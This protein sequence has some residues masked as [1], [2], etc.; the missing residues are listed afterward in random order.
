MAE[1]KNL[2]SQEEI[3]ALTAGIADGSVEVDTGFNVEVRAR[4]H[5]LTNEDSSLGVNVSSIDM[6]NERFIRLFRLG[7]L[8]V[9]RTSPRVNPS[10]TQL[11][12]F[13]DYLKNLHPPCSV[14]VVKVTPL[15]GFSMVLLDPNVIFSSLD[16]FF[17]GAGRGVGQL[18]PGRL[19]TPTESRIISIILEVFFKSLKEAWSPLVALEFERVSSEINPHFAQIADEND[20]VVVNHFDAEC[21][22]AKGFFDIVYPY[23]SIKPLREILRNRVQ[24]ADGDSESDKKWKRDLVAA[25]GDAPVELRVVLGELSLSVADFQKLRAED[26]LFFRKPELARAVVRDVPV[27]EVEPGTAG[28]NMA[29]KIEKSIELMNN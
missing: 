22:D 1:T 17:G 7:L 16:N 3:A 9:L 18:P 8:E 13:G 14:N 11:K 10:R 12:K 6:I 19:F 29:V 2:L 23:S 21:G 15:R 28:A 27:F 25:L 5:D 20:L 24:D 26:V 4:K